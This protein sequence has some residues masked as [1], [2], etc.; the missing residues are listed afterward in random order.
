[1]TQG[2]TRPGERAEELVD[3][4]SLEVYR[5]PRVPFLLGDSA[6][7]SLTAD[8]G[9]GV[10]PFADASTHVMPIGP[11]TLIGLGSAVTVEDLSEEIVGQLNE[12]QILQA[13]RHVFYSP[14]SD[15]EPIIRQIR[16]RVIS[17]RGE[18]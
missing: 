4:T 7:L 9:V 11:H 14:A 17:G 16:Q 2:S 18:A 5:S 13:R 6:V 15:L 8:G 1:M 12:Q 3:A 10:L